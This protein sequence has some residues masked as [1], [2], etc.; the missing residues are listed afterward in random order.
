MDAREEGIKEVVE[1]LLVPLRDKFWLDDNAKGCIRAIEVL[2]NTPSLKLSQVLLDF[3]VVSFLDLYTYRNSLEGYDARK[4]CGLLHYAASKMIERG[5]SREVTERVIQQSF[6]DGNL[7]ACTG[8]N[9]K[10]YRLLGRS[11]LPEEAAWL[12]DAYLKRNNFHD[13]V[14]RILRQ[15][16]RRYVKDENSGRDL[17]DRLDKQYHEHIRRIREAEDRR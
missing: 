9:P 3:I 7:D 10:L 2:V 6:K 13:E 12:V 5:T 15:L 1:A 8:P 14:N 17:I 11:L 16:V 4:D